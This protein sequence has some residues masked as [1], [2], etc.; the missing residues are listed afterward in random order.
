MTTGGTG[1]SA[2]VQGTVAATRSSVVGP[3]TGS[4]FTGSCL[5]W[6]VLAGR[7]GSDVL[8]TGY[9]WRRRLNHHITPTPLCRLPSQGGVA[10]IRPNAIS[11]AI[12]KE[13]TD[14]DGKGPESYHVRRCC[15][16]PAGFRGHG[17][18]LATMAW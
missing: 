1:V 18:G 8:T 11:G 2:G 3:G 14:S 17:Y 13:P 9:T 12:P 6:S 4:A 16:L 15:P 10:G 5:T 7:T